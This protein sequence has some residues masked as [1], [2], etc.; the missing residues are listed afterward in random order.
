MKKKILII[1]NGHGEDVIASNLIKELKEQCPEYELAIVALVGPGKAYKKVGYQPSHINP[2]F[3][4]GGFIRTIKDL[5]LDLKAGI[6]ANMFNQRKHI[7]A[8]SNKCEICIAVGDIFCLWMAANAKVENTYFFPTAKSD[9]FMKHSFIEKWL[10]KKIA[11]KSYPRDQLTTDSF[12]KDKLNAS[13]LGNPM[14]DN[15]RTKRES[16]QL[17][18]DEILIGFLPGSRDEAYK[19]S[20]YC[21]KVAKKLIADNPKINCCFAKAESLDLNI[22]A[23]ESGWKIDN[24][25]QIPCL[26]K[27]KT[28]IFFSNDFLSVINQATVIIGLAGT[29]NE[30]AV[31]LGKPV[32]CFEGFGPQTTLKRFQ[33]QKKLMGDKVII[34]PKRDIS[35]IVKA[36]HDNL[37]GPRKHIKNQAIAQKIVHDIVKSSF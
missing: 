15:L 28:N 25:G 20:Q 34:C 8:I 4:S 33:E 17:K 30:Q 36:I 24:K 37:S 21:L 14:M 22:I 7:K 35:L 19:N 32:I 16:I 12:I 29:A 31:F 10:I 9:L 2:S 18:A 23:K 5:V 13:Y 11:K 1:S 3:P 27:D 6:L 26:T